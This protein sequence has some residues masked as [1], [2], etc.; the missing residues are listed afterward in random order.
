MFLTQLNVREFLIIV[1]R[2]V[3]SGVSGESYRTRNK[4]KQTNKLCYRCNIL[5]NFMN[6]TILA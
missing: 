6:C 3:M 5:R 4:N 1:G 2:M